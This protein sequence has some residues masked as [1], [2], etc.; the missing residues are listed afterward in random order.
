[1]L[2]ISL[3]RLPTMT[4][5]LSYV[6]QNKIVIMA[7]SRR[8][9]IDSEGKFVH[10]D[11]QLKIHPYMQL[12]IGSSGLAKAVIREGDKGKVLEI[13]KLIEH[14]L[15]NN[16]DSLIFLP[17]QTIVEGLV[18]TWN[19]TLTHSLGLKPEDHLANF[20]VCRWE[21]EPQIYVCHSH[22]RQT[23]TA[24]IGAIIGDDEAARIAGNYFVANLNSMKFEETID[25]FKQ[26][27]EQ[28]R[29]NVKTVGGPINIFV[30]DKN[31]SETG[32]LEKE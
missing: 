25:H 24:T 23:R 16:K 27:Y 9:T 14:F 20:M 21:N 5:V 12:V 11:D 10:F 6:W 8:S 31:H 2:I 13:H 29:I 30:L 17:G 1:M 22:N 26:A 15:N 4:M 19:V 3:R 7:D 28:V 32:W 18:D